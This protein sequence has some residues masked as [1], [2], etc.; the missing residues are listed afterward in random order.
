VPWE[1]GQ[2]WPRQV[3]PFCFRKLLAYA[4]RLSVRMRPSWA[5]KPAQYACSP[6]GFSSQKK[7][8]LIPYSSSHVAAFSTTPSDHCG[9]L[10]WTTAL[11]ACRS[12]SPTQV[13]L[14]GQRNRS[15]LSPPPRGTAPARPITGSCTAAR[16]GH[17]AACPLAS[18]CAT[19]RHRALR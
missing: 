18:P 6:H 13:S 11:H 9:R 12:P 4:G 10:H 16:Q 3:I 14:T 2:T 7:R 15:A 8:L 5:C 17:A 1:P 19:P